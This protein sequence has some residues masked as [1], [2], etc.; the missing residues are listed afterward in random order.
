M[1]RVAMLLLPITAFV[2]AHFNGRCRRALTVDATVAG[3]LQGRIRVLFLQ[4]PACRLAHR[5]T[6]SGLLLALVRHGAVLWGR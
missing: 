4:P 5:S 2:S 3:G 6:G 1:A